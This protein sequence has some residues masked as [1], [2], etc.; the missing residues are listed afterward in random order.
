MP[1]GVRIEWSQ[2]DHLF[3]SFLP[4][5]ALAEFA[6]SHLPHISSKAVGARAR[7]LG[8]P[9]AK[10]TTLTAD[11][12]AKIAHS[13]SRHWSDDEDQFLLTNAPRTSLSQLQRATNIDRTAI[14]RRLKE[15]GFRDN[16]EDV[17]IKHTIGTH[18]SFT[19]ERRASIGE[20]SRGR[21]LSPEHRAKIGAALTGELNGQYG[22]GMTEEEKERWRKSYYSNGIHCMRA[23]VESPAGQDSLA[24]SKAIT[25]CDEFAARSSS[26]IS[27][28]IVAGT[29]KPHSNHKCGWHESPKAGRIWYRSSYEERYYTI[30]DADDAVVGYEVE[31]FAI[32]FEFA[33]VTLNYV[34]DV[35][36]LYG[37]GRRELVE[38][39]PAAL[40][41]LPKNA[42][43]L[44]AAGVYAG[45]AGVSFRVVTEEDLTCDP[46]I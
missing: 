5:M 25:Q 1:S 20:R 39:K 30:L 9:P 27:S 22:R 45:L 35:L 26:L 43:K 24:R 15:L 28:M 12:K 31:P 33:G 40:V 32:P 6:N 16:V 11:H 14:W 42:A 2:Y 37:D 3:I 44:V 17:I 38:V 46:G 8:I 18:G 10:R 34:P 13:L 19:P 21:I 7:A 36:L 4:S 23:W 41:T 29:F